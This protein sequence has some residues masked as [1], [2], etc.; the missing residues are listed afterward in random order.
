MSRISCFWP[1]WQVWGFRDR[2]LILPISSVGVTNNGEKKDGKRSSGGNKIPW[3]FICLEI[4]GVLASSGEKLL[5]LVGNL[6]ARAL[7]AP[8]EGR[9]VQ[10]E[11]TSGGR[12]DESQAG[13]TRARTSM[14]WA[15]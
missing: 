7:R 10:R 4:T 3:N 15:F 1:F 2:K 6:I 13:R 9:K 5:I 12:P 14:L 11:T 8:D